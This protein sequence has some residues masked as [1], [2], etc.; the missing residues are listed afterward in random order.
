M[1]GCGSVSLSYGIQLQR[2]TQQ[3]I[4]YD[5]SKPDVYEALKYERFCENIIRLRN[6]YDVLRSVCILG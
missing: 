6:F 2:F 1:R 5:C 3:I 4:S